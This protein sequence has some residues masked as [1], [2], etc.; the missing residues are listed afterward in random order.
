M[1]VS[2]AVFRS[3]EQWWLSD[4]TLDLLLF[5]HSVF[6]DSQ[7]SHSHSKQGSRTYNFWAY[8]R[9][10]PCQWETVSQS[11]AVSHWLGSNL[12][13]ALNLILEW[14]FLGLVQND[15]W[16]FPGLV[17]ID[18]HSILLS[19]NTDP[20]SHTNLVLQ[21]N[22]FVIHVFSSETGPMQWI[23]CQHSLSW[24]PHALA[25]GHQ[26]QQCWIHTTMHCRLFM[27]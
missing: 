4:V 27:G 25:P 11:N 15:W 24:L 10:A 19:A 2:L 7:S 26:W 1:C 5:L 13:S 3:V 6:A 16:Q 20:L 21:I 23:Y 17:Q 18:G 9:F 22:K 14:Q 8:S 12:E